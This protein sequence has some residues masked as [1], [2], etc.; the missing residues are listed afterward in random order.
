MNCLVSELNGTV[1]EECCV[2]CKS[3]EVKGTLMDAASCMN[4]QV[5]KLTGT[6]FEECCVNCKS[7]EVDDHFDGYCISVWIVCQIWEL[8]GTLFEGCCVN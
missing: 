8:S 7:T 6:L 3:A 4:C 1:F 5:S 2:N